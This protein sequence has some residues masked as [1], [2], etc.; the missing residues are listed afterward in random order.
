MLIHLMIV[1]SPNITKL[2]MVL[3][4]SKNVFACWLADIP[5]ETRPDPDQPL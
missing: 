5:G 1:K 3:Q 2:D 4:G